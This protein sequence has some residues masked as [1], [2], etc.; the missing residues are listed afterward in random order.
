MRTKRVRID[1]IDEPIPE[2]NK[3]GRR[4]RF[5]FD[6]LEIGK[7]F[8]VTGMKRNHLGPYKIYAEKHLKRKFITRTSDLGVM[9]WRIS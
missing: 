5:P 9:V 6:Q 2:S 7:C 1:Y 8:R 4:Y 3:R